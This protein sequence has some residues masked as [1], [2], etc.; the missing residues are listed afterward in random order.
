MAL[1]KGTRSYAHILEPIASE[2]HTTVAEVRR[3]MEMAIRAG[4]GSPDLAVHAQWSE[5]PRAGSIPTPDELMDYMVLQ[6][7]RRGVKAPLCHHPTS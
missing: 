4:F 1:L 7:K 2:N 5:V 3:E 6:M